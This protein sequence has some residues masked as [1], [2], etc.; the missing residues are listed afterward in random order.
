MDDNTMNNSIV[1][2]FKSRYVYCQYDPSYVTEIIEKISAADSSQSPMKNMLESLYE[3]FWHDIRLARKYLKTSSS[4]HLVSPSSSYE[5]AEF[6]I[7]LV[8]LE[9]NGW[10]RVSKWPDKGAT[11]RVKS[12][13]DVFDQ[14]ALGGETV[15]DDYPQPLSE[16]L[17][18]IRT[19]HNNT[20]FVLSSAWSFKNYLGPRNPPR[21]GLLFALQVSSRLMLDEIRILEP[22]MIVFLTGANFDGRLKTVCPKM[23]ISPVPDLDPQ[24]LASLKCDLIQTPLIFRICDTARLNDE[25]LRRAICG[26]IIERMHE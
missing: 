21:V 12:L 3:T 7:L 11:G 6:R 8:G 10:V 18:E 17:N 26:K 25:T 13:M 24:H 22:N 23:E 20:E 5:K 1:A 2:A 4:I 16:L 14:S 9:G 19:V 15:R